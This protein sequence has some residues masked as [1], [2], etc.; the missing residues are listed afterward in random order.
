MQR[1][2]KKRIKE[3][4]ST[5]NPSPG[6]QCILNDYQAD[7][8]HLRR[9]MIDKLQQSSSTQK[10]RKKIDDLCRF[11]NQINDLRTTQMLEEIRTCLNPDNNAAIVSATKENIS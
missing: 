11:Y 8:E 3:K 4:L 2:A 1:E 6:Q 10:D 7:V 9:I 5:I